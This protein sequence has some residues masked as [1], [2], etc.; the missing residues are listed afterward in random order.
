MKLNYI[1]N[2]LEGAL[3]LENVKYNAILNFFSHTQKCKAIP[4]QA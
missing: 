3:K 1:S 2:K 4:V